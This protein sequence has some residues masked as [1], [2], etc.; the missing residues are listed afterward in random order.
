MIRISFIDFFIYDNV[1][2]TH[3]I[4]CILQMAIRWNDGALKNGHS[5]FVD[6]CQD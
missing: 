3:P 1:V 2:G 5:V 6:L 4:N